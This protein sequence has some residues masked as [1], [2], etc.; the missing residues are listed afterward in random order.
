MDV[1][2]GRRQ[3]QP[4]TGR[5]RPAADETVFG[6]LSSLL[7]ALCRSR[8]RGRLALLAVGIVIVLCANVVGQIRL[9]VWQGDFFNALN[10]TNFSP[11]S[12][13]FGTPNFGRVTGA[14]LPR[15]IQ[16]G[17]KFWF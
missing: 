13:T 5:L 9:N 7:S 1:G 14:R 12:G 4:P 15:T 3:P 8:Y 2:D 17:M 6:Q 16:I 10:H 11:P